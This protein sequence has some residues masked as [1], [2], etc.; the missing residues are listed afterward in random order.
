MAKI[1]YSR[2]D[3][4]VLCKKYNENVESGKSGFE[5]FTLRDKMAL[6]EWQTDIL[7]SNSKSDSARA[8]YRKWEIYLIEFRKEIL[9]REAEEI[10]TNKGKAVRGV[11]TDKG[12]IVWCKCGGSGRSQYNNLCSHCYGKGYIMDPLTVVT[13]GQYLSILKDKYY[14][15]C[16]EKNVIPHPKAEEQDI[17]FFE[18]FLNK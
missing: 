9:T 12:F 13:E 7:N 14:K 6:A 15:K 11:K 3:K 8:S 1:N 4:K 10:L 18:R 2:D 17:E 16:K 5:G